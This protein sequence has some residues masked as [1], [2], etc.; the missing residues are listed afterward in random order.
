LSLT[1]WQIKPPI[2]HR[3]GA[4]REQTGRQSPGHHA[5]AAFTWTTSTNRG[6]EPRRHELH[7]PLEVE[8]KRASTLLFPLATTAGREKKSHRARWC[9]PSSPATTVG[10]GREKLP[11]LHLRPAPRLFIGV[12]EA[13]PPPHLAHTTGAPRGDE[14]P[15]TGP[16]L[17]PRSESPPGKTPNT[18]RSAYIYYA[19]RGRQCIPSAFRASSASEESLGS[20]QRLPEALDL[21]RREKVRGEGG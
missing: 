5:H 15:S 12:I 18:E 14:P 21:C 3:R 19:Q 7:R 9:S 8:K 1:G 11:P 20:A 10:R 6:V 4:P 2:S 17:G 13:A 16:D